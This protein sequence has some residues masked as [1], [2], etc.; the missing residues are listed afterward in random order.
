MDISIIL[1][2]GEGTR[3]KTKKSKVLHTLLN[4]TMISYVLDASVEA[5]AAKNVIIAG[6]N[7][8][9]LEE[10][11]QEENVSFKTQE[12]GEGIPYGTGYAVSL[13]LEEIADDDTVLILTG[14][15]PLITGKTLKSFVDY[16]KDY[17]SIAT[18][19]TATIEDP[20][21][22]GR[23]V[24]DEQGNMLKIVEHKDCSEE[25][26]EIKEF[27]SGIMA[28]QGKALKDSISKLDTDNEQG[29][30]YL[31]DIFE[32]LREEGGNISTFLID[33]VEEVYGI[34]SKLQL[35]EAEKI[36]KRRVNEK[37]MIDGVVME[38]PERTF[39]EPGVEIGRDTYIGSGVRIFGKTKIGE[40]CEIFGDSFI[41]DSIL[42]DEV[43][44]KSSYIIES[45]IGEGTD[46]GPF[47]HLRPNSKLGKHVHI[48]D[49]VEIKKSTVGDGTKA[50]HLAY[51]GDVDL[52]ENINISCGVIFANYDGKN[53]AR[54]KVGSGSFIGS[55]ANI[56]APCE[57]EEEAYIAA[58]STITK[59]VKKGELAIERGTQANIAGWVD[60]RKKNGKL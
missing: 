39:I 12:I 4:K 53:K 57:I 2:A 45:E 54:T 10:K 49:F 33:D 35:A 50:G 51:L 27:N 40:S 14:D 11:I 36:M 55:N 17:K 44:I 18:V 3:M 38:D 9:F 23:V 60:K 41:K 42:D 1:A 21:G 31:T 25:E 37:F 22:Y 29:E 28:L 8:A 30:L 59:A 5:G 24:K 48:G 46:V 20:T 58:G 34:N 13:A 56:V 32:I 7:R 52:G 6:K 15:I 19:L 26:L 43:V 47:S 16:H